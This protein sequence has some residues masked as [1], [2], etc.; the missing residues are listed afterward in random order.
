MRIR[1]IQLLSEYDKIA[2]SGQEIS[3]NGSHVSEQ[4]K[5]ETHRNE[6]NLSN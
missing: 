3:S 5:V 4:T 2:P 1:I 6:F